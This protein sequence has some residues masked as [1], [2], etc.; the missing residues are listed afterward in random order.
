MKRSWTVESASTFRV[1]ELG[2]QLARPVVVARDL[3]A[4]A[5]SFELILRHEVQRLGAI[6]APSAVADLHRE[7]IA[8]LRRYAA[9]L[10]PGIALVRG[11][12]WRNVARWRP[13]ATRLDAGFAADASRIARLARAFTRRG[14]HVYVQPH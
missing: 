11:G 2:P 12:A 10:K 4:S 5:E 14:Y 9:D 1:S 6:R 13:E 3:L 8:S 7:L